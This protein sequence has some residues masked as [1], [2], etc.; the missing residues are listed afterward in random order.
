M[1]EGSASMGEL[2][3]ELGSAIGKGDLPMAVSVLNSIL[4]K[5]GTKPETKPRRLQLLTKKLEYLNL[6][7]CTQL[8]DDVIAQILKLDPCNLELKA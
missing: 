7:K 1:A 4:H 5:L 8:A 2:E 3:R 6:L